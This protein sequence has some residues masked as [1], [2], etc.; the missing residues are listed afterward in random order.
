MNK[1]IL[2][3]LFLLSFD[4]Q[5][6]EIY[7]RNIFLDRY[8]IIPP[9]GKIKS[10]ATSNNKLFVISDTY[11]LIFDKSNLRLERTVYFSEEI[12]LIGYDP[13][14]DELWISS[15]DALL[16]YNINLG[17]LREYQFRD[18]IKGIGFTSEEVYIQS[19]SRY[20]L[21]RVS[22]KTKSVG[23]LPDNVI[24]YG[25]FDRKI[26]DKYVFLNPFY[27]QDNLNE[28][29][30]P[31]YRYEITAVYDDGMYLYVGT[32]QYGILKY[33]KVSLAKERIV[34]G[35]LST[36]NLRLKKVGTEYY[37]ISPS[38]FSHLSPG[39]RNQWN[40]FRLSNEPGEFSIIGNEYF[41]SFGGELK[42]IIG[43][44]SIP[45]TDFRNNIITINFDEMNI[46]IGTNDGLY[47]LL[48]N[49]NEP[50]EFGPNRYPVHMIYPTPD[51]IF[52]GSENAIYRYDRVLEQWFRVMPW[53]ARD[54]CELKSN[55]YFLTPENQL[56]RYYPGYDSVRDEND[57]PAI[58]LP[59]FNILDIESDGV[60][61]YCATGSGMNYFDPETQ[62]YNPIYNLPR[63][64]YNYVGII[65]QDI[66]AIADRNIYRL[67]IKYRD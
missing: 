27:Y 14:Y 29:N 38:G 24:W 16:R 25:S 45:V 4:L 49:T 64:K 54:V 65:G 41:I 10:I 23:N 11:L 48:M 15:I 32:N 63:I 31:F 51:Q 39:E 61:L 55:L 26:L 36:T 52:V 50:F 62:T 9:L 3:L 35:P 21:D 34:Y 17:S 7:P 56:I 2:G 43:S 66:I 40:Y 59:Y 33:N 12:S 13:F 53:G 46:Y 8:E 6:I 67:P 44:V 57:A 30:D 42:K 20:S 18:T 19:R 5:G 1:K 28:T 47:R 37:F 58:I 22:G 60:V